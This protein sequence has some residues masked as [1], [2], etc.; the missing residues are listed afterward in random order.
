MA[1]LYQ[2]LSFQLFWLNLSR[3]FSP[4]KG[5]LK[6]GAK[7]QTSK[8]AAKNGINPTINRIGETKSPADI[9]TA[10]ERNRAVLPLEEARYLNKPLIRIFNSNLEC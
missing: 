2:K 9:K 6:K 10:P 3:S 8:I 4:S 5:S 7:T 1:S